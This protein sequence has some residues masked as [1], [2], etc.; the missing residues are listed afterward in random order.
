MTMTY[1]RAM[2]S[3][4]PRCGAT[5]GKACRNFNGGELTRSHHNDRFR[6]AEREVERKEKEDRKANGK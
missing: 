2:K 4:C 5:A 1:E 3:D 6:Q